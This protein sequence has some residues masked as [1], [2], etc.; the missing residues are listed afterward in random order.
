MIRANNAELIQS[1]IRLTIGILTYLYISTGIKSNYFD[2]TPETLNQ[3]T[4]V[5]FSFTFFVLGSI[6]FLP[7]SL[8][9][10]YSC[11]VF[12][13]TSTTVSA[14]LTGGINSVYV[15]IYL[16][17]YIGYSSRYGRQFLIASVI[18]TFIGYNLLILTED[19][20]NLLTLDTIA[21][22]LLIIALPIY[23]F[24]LQKKLQDAVEEANA[25]SKA[26][27]EFLSNI[28]HQIRKPIGGIVGMIDLLNKTQLN[29]QQ[30]QYIQALSQSSNSL[31][32][33]IEDVVDISKI[34]KGNIYIGQK[35]LQP[36]TLINSLMHNLAPLAHEKHHEF[37][38]YISDDFPY[39][40]MGDAQRLRQIISN[41]V[42]YA[43]D[44]NYQNGVYINS[45]V[46]GQTSDGDII[47][48]ID[49]HFSQNNILKPLS[50]ELSS[51]SE[52]TL[53]LRIGSQLTRLMNG[54]LTI[55]SDNQSNP[56]I[57]LC[58]NWQPA[59]EAPHKPVNLLNNKRVLI[60][61]SDI[62]S[63]DILNRYCQQSEIETFIAEGHDN[64]IA[65]LIWSQQKNK[66]FD[67]IILADSLKI[68]NTQ[69]LI[70]RIRRDA[71]CQTPVIYTTYINK[72]AFTEQGILHDIQATMIKPVA[73]E[74]LE[75]TLKHLL[76]KPE[77]TPSLQTQQQQSYRLLLAEDSEI[78]ASV[79]YSHLTDLG[80]EV[81]IATDGNTAL[82]AMHKHHYDLVFMDINMPNMNGIEATEQW[83]KLE[84]SSRHL[85]II[86]LT[87]KAT[88]ED[89]EACVAAGMDA[90]LSKPVSEQQLH[91]TL[92]TYIKSR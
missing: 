43:I 51:D 76:N 63:R 72:I 20:W 38:Y 12:D 40:V 71:N 32:E 5:F 13:I 33:I 56:V 25:A 24:S 19:A 48:C 78:N 70:F 75:H 85:P 45:Y 67:A 44:N 83:R 55:N 18:L 54:D 73:R 82:Y 62:I 92:E 59:H 64:L 15:L 42:R 91:E 79:I 10:R 69:E 46:I 29:D 61:D 65:H 90:F 22:L 2:V 23:L 35:E 41:L 26:K 34:E 89:R 21:F 11:L 4:L 77:Q 17:I 68:D 27:T 39:Y 6:F 84:P 14:Y 88:S 30:K 57:Q 86:A 28:T 80:H 1:Y 31:Q 52:D 8:S 47:A 74:V 58:F 3:F 49:I 9:R 50:M 66:S 81:D 36:R 53:A 37:N 7:E 87:A 60:Y 16:W